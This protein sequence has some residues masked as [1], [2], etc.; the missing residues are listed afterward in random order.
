MLE[1][2]KLQRAVIPSGGASA[3]AASVCLGC[4]MREQDA[5]LSMI[6][7]IFPKKSCDLRGRCH[8]SAFQVVHSSKICANTQFG[9]TTLKGAS[10][11][12]HGLRRVCKEAFVG[13]R[14]KP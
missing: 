4:T 6:T 10:K 5:I 14:L 3:D 9:W 11:G 13:W 8:S 7:T 2:P 12:G 1:T